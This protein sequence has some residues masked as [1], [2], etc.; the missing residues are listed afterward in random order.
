MNRVFRRLP[1]PVKLLLIGLIPLALLIY[2]S[3]QIYAGKNEKVELLGSYIDRI[4]QSAHI[5]TLINYLDKERKFSFDYAMKKDK[6]NEVMIQRSLTDSVIQQ[7]EGTTLSGFKSYT[8][9]ENLQNIRKYIDSGYLPREQVMHYYTT[10]I[11][12]I[13]TLNSVSDGSEIY[14]QR[15]HKDLM[16]QKLLSEMITN[17]GIMRSNIYNA[18]YTKKYLV[19]TLAGMIGVH[20]VYKTY[21]TEFLF[22]SSPFAAE[23]Y[24]RIKNN[25]AL[26]PTV[27]YI[28]TLFKQFKPDSSYTADNWWK[29]SNEGMEQLVNLRQ[30]LWNRVVAGTNDILKEEKTKRGRT[31][32][33]LALGLLFVIVILIYIIYSITRS[34]TEMKIAAQ[35]I[36]EGASDLQLQIDSKDVIG[37]LAQSI[38]K[39]DANNKLLAGAADA[40]G[41]GNFSATV[42]PR[43]KEDILGNAIIR[44]RDNMVENIR[45]I[46]YSN[47]QLQLLAE[48]YKTIFYKSPLPKWI[49]DFE[50]LRFLDVNEAAINHYG[51][52]REEFLAMTITDIRPEKDQENFLHHM[53][54]LRN[55]PDTDQ[56][57]WRHVKKNGEIITVEVTAHFIDYNNR[58]ARMAVIMDV[59]EKLKVEEKLAFS[60]E[61]FRSIIEQFPYPVISY[62]P[63]GVCI[64][65]NG[66]WEIMWQDKRENVKGY[67]IRT[68]PQML[69]SGLSHYVEKA[70]AGETLIS[71]P[72]LYDPA[73][74]NQKGR[75]RWMVMTL[76]PLKN[77]GG[78]LREVVLILQ[79]ITERKKTEEILRISEEQRRLIMNAALDAIVTIDVKDSITFWNP[80][81]EKIFGWKENEIKGKLLSET[82]IPIK[83]RERHE[84]GMKHYLKTGEGPVLNKLIEITALHRDGMEFPIEL[85][86]IPVEQGNEK[87]FCAFIRDISGRKKAEEKLRQSHE[88]L[89]QLTSHLQNIREEERASMA[90]EVHDELGQQITCIKM[91]VSWLLKRIKTEDVQEQEKI[92]AIPEL[93]DHTS[94]TVRKIATELRPSIL[95]DFGLIEALGWQSGEFEKRSGISIEFR[96]T[97]PDITIGR[98]IAT[99]LFRIYQ[100]SLTNVARHAAATKIIVTIELR[101]DQ[102]I[103]TIADNGKGFDVTGISHKKT[104][105]LL[106]MRERTLMIGGKYEIASMPG[107]GTTII[108]IVPLQVKEEIN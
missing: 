84:Q 99:P 21:E 51:Y 59:T 13:N 52:S 47:E 48:K 107:K 63:D 26:K 71:D 62:E 31:L 56:K 70:F 78:E 46:N 91:D 16:G 2:A 82:I 88:E 23:E 73:L 57:Y 41:K 32:I 90:R 14:L 77:Q 17:L 7:L 42:R 80:Q 65:A 92:K 15:A 30:E 97:V 10:A 95:D 105:G 60:E 18:L 81:A 66:A 76:Y 34:L 74:I 108:V 29:I 100:E 35:K 79:D 87:S 104:L 8:F 94:R 93:L 101:D 69:S 58:K 4:H 37:S 75:K 54:E 55:N 45:V 25:T 3:A 98:T 44:M 27:E 53:D 19:E 36:S 72:Y 85:S 86:I 103:L 64:A 24:K 40:I 61:R 49:Y 39:I 106:G 20:D 68:D 67:N 83:Y 50:T 28:D 38:L 12:R 22:K 9:L 102:L 5:N 6:R 11:F 1:L 33:F 96:S 89:R 43:G